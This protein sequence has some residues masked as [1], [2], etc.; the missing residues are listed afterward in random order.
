MKSTVENLSFDSGWLESYNQR[1]RKIKR[2]HPARDSKK[3]SEIT[4]RVMA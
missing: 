2:S 1:L 4:G 3:W